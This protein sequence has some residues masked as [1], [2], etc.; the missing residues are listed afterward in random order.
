MFRP[1]LKIGKSTTIILICCLSEQITSYEKLNLLLTNSINLVYF[2]LEMQR[3]LIQTKLQHKFFLPC[4]KRNASQTLQSSSYKQLFPKCV[5]YCYSFNEWFSFHVI[6]RR[7]FLIQMNCYSQSRVHRN[8][9][10]WKS[11]YFMSVI[12][13][14][15]FQC[16]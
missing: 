5:Y 16:Y 15:T 12:S 3:K 14:I 1:A 2:S 9:R 11:R 4:L 8:K 10:F 6:N 13:L 7:L